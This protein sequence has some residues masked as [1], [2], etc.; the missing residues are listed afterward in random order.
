MPVAAGRQGEAA[1]RWQRLAGQLRQPGNLAE[2]DLA[3]ALDEGIHIEVGVAVVGEI[4]QRG[5]R[6]RAAKDD[7]RLWPPP[8][9]LAR[10]GD[11]AIGRPD[12]YRKAQQIRLEG[13]DL[14]DIGG[15]VLA[16]EIDDPHRMP[17]AF[18]VGGDRR[19]DAPDAEARQAGAA[20]LVGVGKRGEA[21]QGDATGRQGAF[22][23]DL[24]TEW[25]GVKNTLVPPS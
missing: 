19:M 25:G 12:V 3:I 5:P 8:P 24:G 10:H 6:R 23:S 18:R 9:D 20:E 11:H 22:G 2:G 16:P 14:V 15:D 17:R 1:N 21:G 4:E 13:E 7:Q